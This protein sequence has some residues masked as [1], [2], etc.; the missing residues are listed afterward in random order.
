M[1]KLD[2]WFDSRHFT[3]AFVEATGDSASVAKKSQPV[4]TARLKRGA[5]SA[6]AGSSW[7]D[8]QKTAYDVGQKSRE[9]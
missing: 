1:N 5:I 3:T 7:S 4:A 6:G 9:S 2:V 8:G